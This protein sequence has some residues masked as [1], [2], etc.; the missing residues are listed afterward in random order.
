MYIKI[1]ESPDSSRCYTINYQPDLSKNLQSVGGKH[2]LTN[3]KHQSILIDENELFHILDRF[4][5][6]K[7]K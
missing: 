7:L 5:K 6:G 3:E 2:H 1:F 4:Y